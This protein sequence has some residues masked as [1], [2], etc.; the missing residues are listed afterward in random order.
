MHAYADGCMPGGVTPA[1]MQAMIDDPELMLAMTDPKFMAFMQ[2]QCLCSLVYASLTLA[3]CE[4]LTFAANSCTAACLN[5]ESILCV[6]RSCVNLQSGALQLVLT[7][8]ALH[9][10]KRYI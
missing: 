10:R 3:M 5:A 7:S 6:L 1:I 2:G 4:S 9:A 8:H